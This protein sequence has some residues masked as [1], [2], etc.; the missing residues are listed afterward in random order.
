[1]SKAKIRTTARRV[2]GCLKSVRELLLAYG[3]A[4][5]ETVRGAVE[6]LIAEHR[7]ALEQTRLAKVVAEDAREVA[8]LAIKTRNAAQT[9]ATR[10]HNEAQDLQRM[11]DQL[12]VEINA[13]RLRAICQTE[14]IKALHD[15]LQEWKITGQGPRQ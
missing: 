5:T 14:V 4:N 7:E 10:R 1:M 3:C 12:L 11:H 15:E 6:R 2:R 13:H 8:S 9:L